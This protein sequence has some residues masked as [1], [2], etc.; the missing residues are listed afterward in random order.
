MR[1]RLWRQRRTSIAAS[2]NY[3]IVAYRSSMVSGG[4]AAEHPPISINPR[5]SENALEAR[6]KLYLSPAPASVFGL[7]VLAAISFCA[8]A[9][10]TGWRMSLSRPLTRWR[11]AGPPSASADAVAAP[12]GP[13]TGPFQ[14]GVGPRNT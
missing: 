14:P 12:V 10:A 2:K 11:V 7:T 9:P 5:I 6:R 4:D 3:A 13:S 8:V 1:M